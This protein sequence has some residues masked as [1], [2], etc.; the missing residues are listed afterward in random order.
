MVGEVPPDLAAR[1]FL[2]VLLLGTLAA[3]GLILFRLGPA[4][5]LAAVLAALLQPVHRKLTRLLRRRANL[6]AGLLV[7]LVVALVLVPAVWLS[8][9]MMRE[10]TAGVRFVADT[11]RSDGVSGLIERLPGPT[12]RVAEKA[13]S[14]LPRSTLPELGEAVQEQGG[15]A[16]A[17]VGTVVSAT[18]TFIFQGLMMLIALYFLLTQGRQLLDWIDEASPLRR[19]QTHELLAEFR[20]VSRSIVVSSAATAGAQAAAGVIGY[21]LARVPHPWFFAALTFFLGFIPAIGGGVVCFS[22]A[23]LLAITGHPYRALFLAIWA[24]V[25]VGLADNVVKPLVMK[26]QVKISGA[27]IFFAL[28]GGLVA[29]GSVGL[30]LGPFA[31][32]GFLA[33]LRMYWRDFAVKAGP[34]PPAGAAPV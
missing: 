16:A 9:F 30:L 21:Y 28:V 29:F 12:R 34:A 32:A 19:G 3:L 7:L 23:V 4:L 17:A 6:S 25:V 13:L 27:V 24:V 1:R 14:V 18:G 33:L 11:L 8:A 26:G 10:V 22:A 15:S 2:F 31:V 20:K 5:V